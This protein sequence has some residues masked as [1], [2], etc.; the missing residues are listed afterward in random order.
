MSRLF[1]KP[2]NPIIERG[3]PIVKGLLLDFPFE[4]RGGLDLVNK[5]GK[6]QPSITYDSFAA[7]D[8]EKTPYGA[9]MLFGTS[10]GY[11]RRLL[12]DPTAAPSTILDVR[13][14]ITIEGIW[15]RNVATQFSMLC[16]YTKTGGSPRKFYI[17]TNNSSV[18]ARIRG[19][20][21]NYGSNFTGVTTGLWMHTIAT[22]DMNYMRVYHN[23]ELRYETAGTEQ[24]VSGAS[25]SLNQ[26][27]IGADRSDWTGGDLRGGMA[28]FR[29]WD[30][31]LQPQEVERLFTN[32]WGIYRESKFTRLI[33]FVASTGGTASVS[34]LQITAT[35]PS[36]TATYEGP[37]FDFLQST[38]DTTDTSAYTFASQNLGAADSNR[39]IVVSAVARKAGSAFTLSSITVGGVSATIVKQITNT[40]T[41]SNTAA[42][43]IAKVPTGTTGDIVVTWSTT[44]LRCQINV[45][46]VVGI[47]SVTA[48]D[49]DSSTAND[50]SVNLDIPGRGFAVG[51]A[52]TA[53][54]TS[55]SWTG[56]VEDSD[57]TLESFVTQSAASQEF[58]SSEVGRTLTADFASGESESAG[59]FA[60]W[61]YTSTVTAAVSPVG[62]TATM[63]AVTATYE[64]VDTAAV[65]PLA[66]T[67]TPTATT[68]TYVQVGTA[69]VA[70]LATTMTVPAVTA[71]YVQVGTAAVSP[72]GAQISIPAV[73]ATY[74]YTNTASVAP[75]AITL[76]PTTTTAIYVYVN[77]ASVSPL[78]TQVSIP[79]VSATYVQIG[80]A[81]VSSLG[82]AITI[83]NVTGG[84]TQGGTAS[85]APLAITATIPAVS[86]NYTYVTT[87]AVDP[88]AITAT[89]VDPSATYV[90]VN[91]A[92]VSP[93]TTTM[94]VP[95]VSATYV[96][97]GTASVS[98]L[99]LTVGIPLVTGDYVEGNQATAAVSPL[100][101]YVDIPAVH[102]YVENL[103]WYT[104]DPQSWQTDNEPAWASDNAPRWYTD[105]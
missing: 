25:N 78:A 98:P 84:Y 104:D 85:V 15:R 69:S 68:A 30:R 77:T 61:E 89:I 59:V 53:A 80:T 73:S 32:P 97:V 93:I 24:I 79:A 56:L 28:L 31:G 81:A 36:V 34:P 41:N 86:A 12:I 90:Y 96:Q 57:S 91:T 23:N 21:T 47:G 83:P 37:E 74:V 38:G 13:D 5:V 49:S 10:E 14:G 8:W 2:P 103:Q 50:P 52:L 17:T 82:V 22:Y 95:G 43:A 99:A 65:A 4:K 66:L 55:V 72:V 29:M 94:T 62:I 102:A 100:L 44:V 20:S 11:G 48:Y 39:Y 76:T 33:G 26:F 105:Y 46:R 101:I 64:E 87:A 18:E 9:G 67:V 54:A 45:W 58:T 60:S 51:A 35:I 3:H 63:P 19:T 92:G 42:L 88:L 75:L 40:G 1:I 27:S 6:I 70:P 7:N 16:S 71:S